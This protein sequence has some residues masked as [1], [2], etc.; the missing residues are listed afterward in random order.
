M[1]SEGQALVEVNTT[2]ELAQAAEKIAK[3]GGEV[4]AVKKR[5]V[6]LEDYFIRVVEEDEG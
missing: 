6:D 2:A 4:I 3:Q 1:L 5:K